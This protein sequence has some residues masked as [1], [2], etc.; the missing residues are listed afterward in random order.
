MR[1]DFLLFILLGGGGLI[2]FFFLFFFFLFF[3][4]FLAFDLYRSW[5]FTNFGF[6]PLGQSA[7][8][9]PL[10]AVTVWPNSSILLSDQ[11][12]ETQSTEFQFISHA[13]HQL[14]KPHPQAKKKNQT[15]K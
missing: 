10:H 2:S 14:P 13:M 3:F 9:T 15:K 12:T 1:C 8:E 11:H 4:F 5:L 7:W 6:P